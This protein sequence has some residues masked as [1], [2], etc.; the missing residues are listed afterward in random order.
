MLTLKINKLH[1]ALPDILWRILCCA[2]LL[3]SGFSVLTASL[4]PAQAA[5]LLSQLYY[6]SMPEDDALEMFY[7]DGNHSAQSPVRSVTSIAIA[8]T[9]TII[10]YDH[11][12]DGYASNIITGANQVWGDSNLTNGCPPNISNTPNPCLT[13]SDDQLSAGQ[14]VTLSNNVTVNGSA[15][16]PYSRNTS[17]VF[18][19]GRDKL[20]TTYPVAVNRAL[21]P[22]NVGSLQAGGVE[23]FDTTLW[24]AEYISPY[25]DGSGTGTGL[26]EDVRLFVIAGPGGSTIS[27]DLND[28]GDTSDPGEFSGVVLAEGGKYV[29]NRD[30]APFL[31]AGS[32]L[33]VTSGSNVQVNVLYADTAD[34]YELRWSAL[35]PISNWSNDYYSPVGTTTG[36]QGCTNIWVFN[37]NNRTIR[38]NYDLGLG[39]DGFA[40]VTARTLTNLTQVGAGSG[41]RVYTNSANDIFLPFS[42]TDC[43]GGGQ[44]MDWD[45][46]LFPT[47]LLTPDLLVGWA[48]GCTDESHLGVCRDLDGSP[49]LAGSVSRSVIW[50]TPVSNTTIYVDTNGSGII[51]PGGAGAE[52]TI[53]ANALLSYKINNNGI[54]GRN[55]VRDEFA[56][57]AYNINGPNN[58]Q[59]WTT[60]W[61]ETGDDNNAG[62]GSIR[63]NGGFLELRNSGTE[64]GDTI[65]RS[66]DLS[67]R[68]FARFSFQ[69]QGTSTE[70]G[71]AIAAEV[72]PDGGST[73]YLLEQFDGTINALQTKVYNI[74]PYIS[75]NTTIRFRFI[76]SLESGDLWQIDNVNIEYSTSGDFDMTG[77][78]I[79]TC[80][81]VKLA[82]AYGQDPTTSESGDYEALDLGTVIVPYR[83]LIDLS[84][85]KQVSNS[86]PNLGA[87]VTFSLV[88][89]NSGAF[90][91]ATNVIM[92]DVVP[93]GYAYVPG[94][95]AGGS[96]RN[97]AN[98]YTSGLTW[99]INSLAR[100]DSTTLTYQAVVLGGASQYENC[101]EITDANQPDFDSV[102]GNDSSTEDDDDCQ[103]VTPKS[104][105]IGNSVWL[106]ENGDG[107]QDAGE[108]GIANLTVELWNADHT[109]LLATTITD[110]NGNYVFKDVA[111]GA[112]Q[113]DVLDSS[114]PSGLVQT[115]VIG[116]SADGT[117]KADPYTLT[118]TANDEALQADFGFNWAP[119]SDTDGNTGAGAIGDRLW[120]DDGDG[121]QE[122]GEPGMY[123]V[124]VELL[125]PGPDGIFGTAD[126]VVAATTT[127]GYDGSYIFD[128]LAAGAY[129]IRVNGGVTPTGYTQTGDPDQPG[130]ACT[131]CDN[132]T[133]TPILLAPGDVYVNADFGYTPTAGNG[134]NIG[135][136][137]WVDADRDAIIDS[138]EPR[139]AGVTVSL[140]RDL[141]GDGVWDPGEPIIASDVTNANGEYLFTNLPVAD[142]TGTDDYLVWVN[143]TEN[144]L[145]GLVPTYDNNGV[146]TPNLSAVTNL[147]SAGDTNQDFAYAPPGHANGEGL[148]GDTIFY[149]QDSDN[150][151]DAGEGLEGVR[152]NLYFDSNGDGNYDSGEPLIFS[153]LTNE[154]GQ[155]FF[156]NLPAGNYVVMVDPT[157]LPTGVTNTY[158]PDTTNSPVNEAG[159]T[160]AAGD[161]NL[162]L[163]FGY[164]DTSAPNSISGTLWNDANADGIL[165]GES[166]RFQGVTIVLRDSS[167][168]IIATTTTDA[169]GNYSFTNLPDGTYTVDV[170][171]ENNVL[172]GYWHSLG[173][174][175]NDNNS[176]LDPYTITVTNGQDDTTADFGY[177]RNPSQAGNFVWLDLNGDGVQ[178]ANE[179]GLQGV[180]VTLTITYPNATVVTLKTTS[181][182]NGAY[183][184]GNLLLDEDFDGAGG[185]EPVYTI[186]VATPPGMSASPEA[187]TGN[188]DQVDGDSDGA[189]ET[190]TVLQGET[191]NS[192]D[193]GFN[194]NRDMGDLPENISGSPNYPTL[195]VNGPANTVFPDGGDGEPDTAGGLIAV[196]LGDVVDTELEGQPDANAL[197]DGSDED[198]LWCQYQSWV[199]GSTADVIVRINSSDPT[200][201]YFGLWIDWD[202][203]GVFDDFYAGS[204]T[205]ASPTNVTV[206]IDIPTSFTQSDLIYIRLR[207]STSP[208][209]SNDYRGTFLNGETEDYKFPYSPTAVTM[210]SF[211]GE[212]LSGQVILNWETALEF[213]LV[214]FNVYRSE[215]RDGPREKLNS[216]PIPSH[217][218]GGFGFMY[219]FDAGAIQPGQTYFY[220]LEFINVD[221]TELYRQPVIMTTWRFIFL[222]IV[223]H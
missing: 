159:L 83:A 113:V 130:E 191:D 201:V 176:Q 107:Y 135:D 85:D 118:V 93:N 173:T 15:G 89:S 126:D 72:S 220:W 153:T 117:N 186:S 137:L 25:A 46:S 34:T 103:A 96:S 134:G 75:N 170:T 39:T 140:I 24:G 160:L 76:D 166:G 174:A 65:Q 69:I 213:D 200:T 145:F 18:F 123:N 8:T 154:S 149:D 214:G 59:N 161:V 106:D 133:T 152:V 91:T 82:A 14:V 105:T 22:L 167:G 204:G 165:S 146:G 51:C 158:D 163:D 119:S 56:T 44:I 185:G 66:R 40:D 217:L 32:R 108:A 120:I 187:L 223:I 206:T 162:D 198:G 210:V 193:F 43:T 53:N 136:T 7:D 58:T 188:D 49:N 129:A 215:S 121:I 128:G 19:D 98:P 9:G 196:W 182:S 143:D 6:L 87:T 199:A 125:T 94:S 155:Y 99:T 26:F 12:E 216:T 142:G 181:G 54:T 132:R 148:I 84:L 209:T 131:T 124:S 3:V 110:A 122:P 41:V 211:T 139:L 184:F 208:L 219:E 168:K 151:P 13:N 47:S 57:A 48:P 156:G 101:A 23:M 27:L 31:Q 116:G 222:P 189:A 10:Y 20:Q 71:D 92:T 138:A 177:Y 95:I 202:L 205:T 45:T 30:T 78:Y 74:S 64:A 190:V 100:G 195:F 86:T 179:P 207:A 197:G 102:P 114:L 70:A 180:E 171:D 52:Q 33:S 73:W 203:D 79:R 77:S 115:T 218:G 60:N 63:I 192:Y 97:D 37:P 141:D 194:G 221:G 35:L 38:I 111:P 1:L 172:D 29:I 81:G 157:T 4:Q 212:E 5:P 42:V 112:Y 50:V 55:N 2:I 178:D 67:G 164:R 62:S 80:D 150:T 183:N 88:V 175:G 36:V 61:T 16:G 17:E 144:V 169:S 147:T 127:T 28:D 68:I 104:A 11:W 109:V 21:F 90:N